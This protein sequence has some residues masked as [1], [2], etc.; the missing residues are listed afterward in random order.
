MRGNM[1]VLASD[2]AGYELKQKIKNWLNK[3]NID[4]CDVGA[5]A[6]DTE[7]SFVTYAK[8]AVEHF[9]KTCKQNDRLLLVCGSGIGMSIV[10]NRHSNIRA[11]LAYSKKQARAGRLHTDCNCL[12]LGARHIC[13][14]KAKCI[15]NTF[16]KTEFLGGKYLDRINSI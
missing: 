4:F 14:L 10:A 1:I 9:S 7:D 2:H 5:D 16:L 12:C 6:L 11:V 13:F 15:I 3:R 8:E